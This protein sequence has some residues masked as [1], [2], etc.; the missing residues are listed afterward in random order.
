MNETEFICDRIC[1][2]LVAEGEGK[3]G[4]KYD[5]TVLS[6]S[7]AKI[8]FLLIEIGMKGEGILSEVMMNLVLDV[9]FRSQTQVNESPSFQKFIL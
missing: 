7:D 2:H 4:V 1:V 3:G 9:G 8:E 5:F 6:Q